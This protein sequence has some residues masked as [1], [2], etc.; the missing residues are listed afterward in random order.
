[1]REG[2][3]A[4]LFKATEAAQRQAERQDAPEGEPRIE[5]L[6]TVEYRISEFEA[7]AA[8]PEPERAFGAPP[9][10]ESGGRR[11][12]FPLPNYPPIRAEAP[13]APSRAMRRRPRRYP[14]SRPP[15]RPR[16]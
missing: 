15:L 4:E 11:R 10:A 1:M 12:R 16:P 13:H 9:A 6:P 2:P 14:S 5:D 8:E 7:E 3:L